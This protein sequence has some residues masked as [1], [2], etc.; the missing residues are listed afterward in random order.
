MPRPIIL[1]PQ[2]QFQPKQSPYMA[3]FQNML[4]QMFMMKFG[5]NIRGQEAETAAKRLEGRQ[6]RSDVR[7]GLMAGDIER[8]IPAGDMPTKIHGVPEPGTFKV[9]GQTYKNIPKQIEPGKIPKGGTITLGKSVFAL[10]YDKQ[11]GVTVGDRLGAAPP[12]GGKRLEVKPD[13]TVVWQEGQLPAMGKTTRGFLEK[14]EFKTSM[15]LERIQGVI[16]K[17]KPEFQELG[18]RWGHWYKATKEKLGTKLSLIDKKNL[19]EY[20]TYRKQAIKTMNEEILRMGGTQIPKYEAKRLL[21]GLPNVGTGLFGGDSPTE[22]ISALKSTQQD[23]L[24]YQAMTRYYQ[25]RNL[26]MGD[27]IKQGKVMSLGEFDNIINEYGAMVEEALRLRE[28]ELER[29]NLAEF[30]NKVKNEI[31]K[32]FGL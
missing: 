2:Q 8:Q 3:G 11:G 12:R 31:R 4:M 6:E 19:A 27:L 5:A 28:P 15:G 18:T 13:G 7:R 14:E 26:K 10:K 21:E 17:F 22:F 1:P 16:D 25:A 32:K 30:Y 9:G 24:K 20:S 23:L 29:T